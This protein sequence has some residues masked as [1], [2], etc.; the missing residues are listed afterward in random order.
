ML[1]DSNLIGNIVTQSKISSYRGSC[2]SL[3]GY[4]YYHGIKDDGDYAKRIYCV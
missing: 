1:Y 3:M 4:I 2:E